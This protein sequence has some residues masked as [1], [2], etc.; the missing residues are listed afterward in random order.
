MLLQNGFKSRDIRE[1]FTADLSA[2][3]DGSL[4]KMEEV[5]PATRAE[6]LRKCG[7]SDELYVVGKRQGEARTQG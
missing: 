5:M 4:V 7:F 2:G 3:N 1:Q 6:I